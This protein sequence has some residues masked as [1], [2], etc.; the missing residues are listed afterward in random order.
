MVFPL[1]VEGSMLVIAMIGPRVNMLLRKNLDQPP[2]GDQQ[3][4]PRPYQKAAVLDDDQSILVPLLLLA[5]HGGPVYIAEAG[6]L[7]N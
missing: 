6:Q 3:S 7:W 4:G 2:R 1:R 5:G